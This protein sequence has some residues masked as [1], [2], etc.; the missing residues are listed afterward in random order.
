MPNADGSIER[1]DS[2]IRVAS[3]F[4][5]DG[6]LRFE[7]ARVK[8]GDNR[9]LARVMRRLGWTGPKTLRMGEKPVKG[10]VRTC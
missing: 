2:E 6:V 8:M 10:Y 9:R 3:E 7:R 1:V 5:L 4:L